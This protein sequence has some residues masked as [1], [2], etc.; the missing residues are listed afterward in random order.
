MEIA[1]LTLSLIA[2]GA[3]AAIIYLYRRADKA[4][5]EVAA[6][7]A[8]LKETVESHRAE[9]S[10]RAEASQAAL[11]ERDVTIA[12][13]TERLKIFE[14]DLTRREADNERRFKLLAADIIGRESKQFKETQEVRLG[15][16]LEPLKQ[17]VD[18]LGKSVRETYSAEARERF[19]LAERIK[20]LVDTNRSIGREAKELT[21]ALRGNSKVQGDWGEMVLETILDKSGLIKDVH[22]RVQV[23][24]DDEG[25]TLR[26]DEGRLLR[27]DVVINYP[28]GHAVVVDS[29]VSLTAFMRLVAAQNDR[30]R[31]EAAAKHL[32]SV[33]AHIIELSRKNYQDYVG[34]VKS[35]FVMMFIPN[36]PAYIEAMR[37]D[38]NLW[39]E[40]YDRRVL[41][42]SPTQ[43]ISALRLI[44]RLWQQDRQTRNAIE[45]ATA[46]GRM[47][48]KFCGFMDDM[49]RI[50][51]AL[52]NTRAAYT[53][54]MKKLSDG[55]GN[56]VSRAQKLKE[57]GAKTSKLLSTPEAEQ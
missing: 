12:T 15:Q 4:T 26:D 16:I 8:E 3:L 52:T 41:I 21:E 11:G 6:L 40:A 17:E 43:L 55:T 35:D 32:A 42:V 44:A 31:A 7:Q 20:E 14:D 45:I 19:S 56:L 57:L 27:P 37:L 53:D 18:R 50:D 28:G 23:T 29:K 25:H 48:D 10:R 49:S 24:T 36:E 47:Y 30:E 46:A 39:Q 54:A 38:T 51:K 1:I 34:D 13:L 22:Y 2:A 5:A 33:R 9:M